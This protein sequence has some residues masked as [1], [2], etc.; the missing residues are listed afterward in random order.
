MAE[1]SKLKIASHLLALIALA[2]VLKLGLLAALLSG[3]LTYQ[4]FQLTAPSLR[5]LRR[6]H[7][8]II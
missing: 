8:G 5:R 3:L 7:R 1:M 2:F 6:A 4:L